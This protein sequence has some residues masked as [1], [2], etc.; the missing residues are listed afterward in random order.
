MAMIFKSKKKIVPK[1][2]NARF[3]NVTTVW[4]R[5]TLPHKFCPIYILYELPTLSPRPFCKLS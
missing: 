5:M 3:T 4:Y 2:L 1:Q